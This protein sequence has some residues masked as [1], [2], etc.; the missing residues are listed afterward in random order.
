MPTKPKDSSL[1]NG[2]G[3]VAQGVIL[4]AFTGVIAYSAN[5]L[6]NSGVFEQTTK[7]AQQATSEL[8]EQVITQRNVEI[9][10]LRARVASIEATIRNWGCKK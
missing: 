9:A 10:D 1:L 5:R 3:P 2:L 6:T 8:R 7:A 4:F